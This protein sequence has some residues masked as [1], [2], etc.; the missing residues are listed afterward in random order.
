MTISKQLINIKKEMRTSPLNGTQRVNLAD[1]Y[2]KT[3]QYKEALDQYV[4]VNKQDSTM[5][6]FHF[7]RMLSCMMKIG[8]DKRIPAFIATKTSFAKSEWLE[9]LNFNTELLA[10]NKKGTF[11]F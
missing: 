9:N 7:N 1:S 5:S 4:A 8:D 2:Y 10:N 3:D 6:D 11:R